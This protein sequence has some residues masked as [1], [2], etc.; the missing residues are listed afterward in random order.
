ME[1][2]CKMIS[3]NKRSFHGVDTVK[4]CARAFLDEK[5]VNQ[6]EFSGEHEYY[7]HVL[8]QIYR[9]L[10]QRHLL[11]EYENNNFKIPE[12]SKLEDICKRLLGGGRT[13]IEWNEKDFDV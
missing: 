5:G 9:P 2:L 13:Y 3:D 11:L 4:L 1:C 7:K 12:D 6:Y 10:V 8:E